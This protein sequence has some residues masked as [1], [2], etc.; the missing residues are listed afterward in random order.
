M[1]HLPEVFQKFA[2]DIYSK[3]DDPE[4]S[5][6]TPRQDLLTKIYNSSD[7]GVKTDLSKFSD[8]EIIELANN[9]KNGVPIIIHFP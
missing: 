1:T 7:A 6:L 8:N 9:L 4:H 3:P 5:I 2:E